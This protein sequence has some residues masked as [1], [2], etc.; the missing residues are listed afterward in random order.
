MYTLHIYPQ[1][2]ARVRFT[3]TGIPYN[4]TAYRE[5][6]ASLVSAIKKLN[7]PQCHYIGIEVYFYF[8]YPK[9]TPKKQLINNAYHV[10]KPDAD[11]CLKAIKDALEKA[12]VV[13]NDSCFAHVLVVKKYTLGDGH[14]RFKLY[15][16]ETQSNGTLL[17]STL[18]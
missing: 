4:T 16:E 15:E 12:E 18:I 11:N 10:K 1:A 5:Y 8:T 7:I 14:I 6:L 3:R 13:L 2:T 17:L 9:S